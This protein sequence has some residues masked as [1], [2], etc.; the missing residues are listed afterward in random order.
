MESHSLA[1]RLR[2]VAPVAAV[3]V[4]ALAAVFVAMTILGSVTPGPTPSPSPSTVAVAT[5]SP[6]AAPTPV[7]TATPSATIATE[8]QSPAPTGSPPT[9]TSTTASAKDSHGI[10]TVS[11]HYPRLN[12]PTIPMIDAVNQDISDDVHLQMQSFEAGPAAVRQEAGKVNTLTGSYKVELLRSDVVSFTLTWVDDT[13]GAHPATTIETLN[14]DLNQGVRIAFGDVF[15]DPTGA[16]AI[17]SQQ[18][19]VLLK[20]VLGADYDP[21][22]V[23]DGT[24]PDCLSLSGPTPS[25]PESAGSNFGTWALNAEGFKVIFQEYQVG[26]YADGTPSVVVPWSSLKGVLNPDGPAAALAR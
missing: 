20:P 16:T 18:S 5:A 10:W 6:T 17:L 23:T 3:A 15:A 14:Y 13:S 21:A 19:R 9:V 8:S 4:L 2:T 11:I 24:S 22:I 12:A 25:C 7:L 1:D 26:A